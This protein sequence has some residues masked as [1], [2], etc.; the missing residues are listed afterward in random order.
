FRTPLKY[1][2]RQGG[3]ATML[4]MTRLVPYG[5]NGIIPGLTAAFGFEPA[6]MDLPSYGEPLVSGDYVL[7]RP[8]TVRA[9]GR[10][11]ARNPLPEY[12]AEAAAAARARGLSVVSVAD[13]QPGAEWALDP[14]PEADVVLPAGELDTRQLLALAQNARALIGGIGWIIPAALAAN[15]PAWIVCGGQG[16]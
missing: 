15:V 5:R 13:L 16:A 12:V 4:Y 11:E 3:C 6:A 10:A 7:V 14:L 1:A 8:V 9:E 2:R